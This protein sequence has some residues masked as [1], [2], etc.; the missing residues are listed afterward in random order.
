MGLWLFPKIIF[1]LGLLLLAF[2]AYLFT[3][4]KSTGSKIAV[5][6]F[7]FVMCTISISLSV[8]EE[9]EKREGSEKFKYI[10]GHIKYQENLLEKRELRDKGFSIPYIDGL[11]ENPLLKHF[12]KS[13]RKYQDELKFKEAVK[14]FKNCLSHPSATEDNKVAANILIGICYQEL[15]E[16]DESEKHYKEALKISSGVKE[17]GENSA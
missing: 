14:E 10:E 5:R 4:N 16:L 9:I 8:R 2:T 15:Y 7:F 11:G 17:E 3:R 13:G 1:N 12:F 6:G